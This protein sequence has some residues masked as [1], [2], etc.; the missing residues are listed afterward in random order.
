MNPV[1]PSALQLRDIHTPGVPE[2]WPPAPG[3][4]LLAVAAIIL[5]VWLGIKLRHYLRFRRQRNQV[6]QMLDELAGRFD[7]AQAPE[8]LSELSILLR[9]VALTRFP[10]RQVASL[11]GRDWLHFLDQTGGNG[12][13]SD[14]P[15]Q[16][17]ASGP[18]QRESRIEPGAL[19]SL[20]RDWIRKNAGDRS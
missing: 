9:R 10:R 13:F 17:I 5:L 8:W 20:A 12:R 14:G 11:H 7:S 2:F 19:I 4:W 6:L 15:G 1:Q 16:V 3:W 18:Y